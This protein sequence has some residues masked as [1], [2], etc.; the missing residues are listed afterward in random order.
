MLLK[1]DN[2][3]KKNYGFFYKHGYH[4][5]TWYNKAMFLIYLFF[6]LEKTCS[7][8]LTI[9]SY[10][11]YILM[12]TWSLFERKRLDHRILFYWMVQCFQGDKE[13]F[14]SFFLNKGLYF[15]YPGHFHGCISPCI[16]SL[17]KHPSSNKILNTIEKI[18][19]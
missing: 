8:Y 6:N 17:W 14:S 2:I 3:M 18:Y 12:D 15:P 7:N 9:Q 10:P 1:I 5:G 13:Q 4:Q 11:K 19:I 16:A